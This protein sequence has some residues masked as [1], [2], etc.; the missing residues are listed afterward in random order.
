[1]QVGASIMMMAGRIG[2]M[3]RSR[4][5][6]LAGSAAG[7]SAA[8]NT[9]LAGIMFAIEEMARSFDA[10]T[11]GFVVT[12]VIIAGLVSLALVGNYDYFGTAAGSVTGVE[13]WVLVVACGVVGGA[14]GA[15]FSS[16]MLAGTRRASRLLAPGPLWRG[17]ALAGI[18]GMAVAVIGVVSGGATFGTG[19]EHAK[20]AIE[21]TPV[22]WYFAPL[23]LLATLLSSLSGIPGGIFAP[24]L[25]VGTG[26]GSLIG[27]VLGTSIAP[28]ALL[29]MTGYF[30]GV[31]QAPI[32]AFVIILE[33]TAD[34]KDVVPVMC[35]ALLG[36]G[37][38]RLLSPESLYHGLA[39]AYR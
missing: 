31:V 6:I 9:P 7:I 19:Y 33:M 38:S 37:V 32:T 20:I 1:V 26:L 15:L 8:F 12:A 25:A 10:R 14:F 39:K 5:L 34:T 29:G 13:G 23:K 36:Y 16:A 27:T 3:G 17:L 2:G 4:G 24:S 11:S 30:A 35:A 18:C 28:A 21:G 22:T